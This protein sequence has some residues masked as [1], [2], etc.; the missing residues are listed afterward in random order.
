VLRIRDVYP[1]SR[2]LIKEFKYFNPKK[3]KKWFLSS[4]KYDPGCSSRIP[5]PDADFLPSRIP[6]SKMHPIPDPG[7]GSATL[8]LL[9]PMIQ[10][11]TATAFAIE[12]EENRCDWLAKKGLEKS[13]KRVR[14]MKNLYLIMIVSLRFSAPRRWILQAL[15][16]TPVRRKEL[17]TGRIAQSMWRHRLTG[18]AAQL[19]AG[20]SLNRGEEAWHLFQNFWPEDIIFIR[21]SNLP[22]LLSRFCISHKKT[23][24]LQIEVGLSPKISFLP[25]FIGTG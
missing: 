8:V 3:A 25:Y 18:Q 17:G 19:A 7:S 20:V 1:G 13:M 15:D 5:D 12:E 10:L 6:E 14:T 11:K 16:I 23:R 4:K 9:D 22:C 2:I 21:T 24:I